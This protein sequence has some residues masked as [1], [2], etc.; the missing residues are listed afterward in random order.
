MSKGPSLADDLDRIEEEQK[1]RLIAALAIKTTDE[2]DAI[3]EKVS[4][5]RQQLHVKP[6]FT[7]Q[8][9]SAS[10]QILSFG[11]A[12]LGLLV[13]FANRLE[14]MSPFYLRVVKLTGLF[15]LDLTVASFLVLILFFFQSRCRYPFL[16][17]K[18]LGNAVPFFYYETL[19]R[20]RWTHWMPLK[21]AKGVLEANRQYLEGFAKFTD[22]SLDESKMGRA[23]NELQQCF[24]LIAYQGYLD[25]FEMQLTHLFLYTVIAG[26]FSVL[27][28]AVLCSI[29]W[30]PV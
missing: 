6:E 3:I 8:V 19:P 14:E 5:R 12:G 28:I 16:F 22:H 26:L 27:A 13:A 4:Q 18:Q 15:Y 7:P 2:L 9:V 11:A 23:R 25:Q 10:Q 24:L 17:L 1:A 29:P 30:P 21:S 20:S